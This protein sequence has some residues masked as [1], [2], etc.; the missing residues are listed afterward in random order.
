MEKTTIKES[1]R[2][3]VE[4]ILRSGDI[5]N[6][7]TAAAAKNAMQEGSRI[8]RKIQ[9][10]MKGDYAA[11]QVLS[12]TH[13]FAKFILVMEGRADGIFTEEGITT[14][15]EIK[16][17]YRN[18]DTLTAPEMVHEAQAKCYAYFY[19]LRERKDKMQVQLTYCHLESEEIR[20]FKSLYTIEE[21]H[22]WL[23]ALLQ[24]YEKWMQWQIDWRRTRNASMTE[25]E[26]PFSYRPQQKELVAGVYRTIQQQKKLFLQAP[27]GIGKTMATVYPAVRYV[28][29]G[30][31]G[32]IFYLTA[33]TITR[34]VAQ[35][36]FML[37]K[38]QGLAFK[39][40]TLTAR[41]KICLCEETNCN[42]VACPYARGHFDR[43]NEAVFELLNAHDIIDARQIT[44]YA[45]THQVCPFELS[46]DTA[47]W[48]DAVIC[49]YHYAFD[50]NVHLRRFFGEGVS[51]DYVFLIDEAHNL[52][53]R[54]REMYSATLCKEHV[55]QAGRVVKTHHKKLTRLL[56]KLNK[57]MLAYKREC[58]ECS[59]L[60]DIS[61]LV[62]PLMSILGEMETFFETASDK[63][64]EELLEFYFEI[65][66]FLLCFDL[67]DENYSIYAQLAPDGT[68]LVRLFCINPAVNLQQYLQKGRS[69]V[70]FSATLL[71]VSYYQELYSTQEDDYAMY[72]DSPF[73]I[74]NRSILLAQD[75]SSRYTRR[76]PREFARIA[77]YIDKMIRAKEGNYMVFFP[78]HKLLSDVL[79]L[80][81]TEY[82]TQEVSCIVQTPGMDEEMRE[83][84]LQEFKKDS[85]TLLAFCVM[86]G[87]FAEGI[88]LIGE[89]LIGVCVVGTGLPQ[90][91]RERDLLQEFYTERGQQGFEYAYRYPGM[92][93][94]L[95]A[96]GRVIRTQYDTGVILLLDDRFSEPIYGRLFPREWADRQYCRIQSVEA[97]LQEFWSRHEV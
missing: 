39:V 76:G 48:V 54:A 74:E 96:A 60:K 73:P 15:D 77:S 33:K 84:F 1:V 31:S 10:R 45:R 13:E 38:R 75:V 85:G 68:F 14:I 34:T 78:S 28:G 72:A 36:A 95:Q 70:F 5:D 65:R 93:K 41:D 87:I 43:I 11:E 8:H 42:P 64:H 44:E 37:L 24:E 88:D 91:S 27:T 21:L 61:D 57:A 9:K 55:M 89:H 17:V 19:G 92:N 22:D 56:E 83:S 66:N 26:F 67:L 35:E 47:S 86:G 46:L 25:L 4:F 81:L 40:L 6:R 71:P 52:V 12:Y 53:D 79:E 23:T 16:G 2:N 18:L 97:Q 50:P 82:Q 7:R 29:T 94:V 20:R 30:D 90:V 58:E 80:Y 49:D 3:F 62:F 59:I 32:K 51:G 69:A 63:L